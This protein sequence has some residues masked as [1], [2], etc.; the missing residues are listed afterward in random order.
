MLRPIPAISAV[1]LVVISH[2]ARKTLQPAPAHDG[3]IQAIF[4][5]RAL[6]LYGG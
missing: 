3:E 6:L 1:C 4:L 2:A 5:A